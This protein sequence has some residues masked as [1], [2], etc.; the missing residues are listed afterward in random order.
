[1]AQFQKY[2]AAGEIHYFI[3]GGGMGGGQ[4]GDG[5]SSSITAWVTAHY[6]ATTV[7]GVTVY[8][9]TQGDDHLIRLPANDWQPWTT[10]SGAVLSASTASVQTFQ[11]CA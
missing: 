10:R 1:M 2:V 6:T 7:G 3:A 8:D 11:K 5:S 9:L 4:G